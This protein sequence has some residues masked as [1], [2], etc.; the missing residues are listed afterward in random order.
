[1]PLTTVYII[2][3][4]MNKPE[5]FNGTAAGTTTQQVG[6]QAGGTCNLMGWKGVMS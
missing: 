3:G 2:I 5:F 6:Q 4:E 1:M